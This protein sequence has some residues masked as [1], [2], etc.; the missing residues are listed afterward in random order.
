[1]K[2]YI[3]V[4]VLNKEYEVVFTLTFRCKV[5]EDYQEVVVKKSDLLTSFQLQYFAGVLLFYDSVLF[6]VLSSFQDDFINT[7]RRHPCF[8]CDLNRNYSPYDL[9]TPR[10]IYLG[11]MT[12]KT[13]QKINGFMV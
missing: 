10:N 9:T 4:L 2:P 7:I 1:M 11:N 8:N 12:N 13:P 5:R 6:D 3:Q